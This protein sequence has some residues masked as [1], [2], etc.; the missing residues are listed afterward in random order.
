M[1]CTQ[2]NSTYN[3][4]HDC[5]SYK[6]PGTKIMQ[7]GFV[8]RVGCS[9]TDFQSTHHCCSTHE[10]VR[11]NNTT[12]MSSSEIC[13]YICISWDIQ[14]STVD[15][16]SHH[17]VLIITTGSRICDIVGSRNISLPVNIIYQLMKAS[18]WWG[19]H[20]GCGLILDLH[21]AHRPVTVR[22]APCT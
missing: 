21:A 9:E 8:L 13:M 4:A 16:Y 14:K 17:E 20:H 11:L 15:N 19:A 7:K 1:F 3:H 5:V 10:A 2:T 22:L 12:Y 18:F 6:N